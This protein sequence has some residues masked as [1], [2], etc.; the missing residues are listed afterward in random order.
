MDI[1]VIAASSVTC[2]HTQQDGKYTVALTDPKMDGFNKLAK[3]KGVIWRL[4]P[5]L[6]HSK[7]T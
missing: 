1:I 5:V 7:M 3:V 6:K 2:A 4:F